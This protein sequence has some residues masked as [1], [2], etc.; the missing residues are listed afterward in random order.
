MLTSFLIAVRAGLSGWWQKR[1]RV[2][3]AGSTATATARC[4]APAN[5]QVYGAER[6]RGRSQRCPPQADT[7]GYHPQEGRDERSKRA[8]CW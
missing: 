5:A 6:R 8:H 7:Q 2:Q 4:A 3:D 1:C